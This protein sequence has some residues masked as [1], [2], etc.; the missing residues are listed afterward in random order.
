M[1]YEEF[2]KITK[3]LSEPKRAKILDMLSCG[4]MCACDILKHFDFTQPTLSHHIKI[5]VKA[6]LV[7]AEKRGT[8][9]HYSINEQVTQQYIQ[10]TIHLLTHSSECICES[11]GIQ[12]EVINL[13]SFVSH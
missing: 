13:T 8:W 7:T 9:Q 4:E 11:E 10:E 1:N 2:A 3:A 6:G 12:K 5:L